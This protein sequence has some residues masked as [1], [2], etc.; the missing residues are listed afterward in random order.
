[1]NSMRNRI[2][3][4]MIY[5]ELYYG[6]CNKLDKPVRDQVNRSITIEIRERPFYRLGVQLGNML[7]GARYEK[8]EG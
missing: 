1:M 6:C 3:N 7:Q 2:R 5:T 4:N 8:Y